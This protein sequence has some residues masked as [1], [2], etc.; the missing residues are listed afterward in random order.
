VDAGNDQFL[1]ARRLVT[2]KQSADGG[3]GGR[4]TRVNF[5]LSPIITVLRF[6]HVTQP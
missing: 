3:G 2:A 4:E 6:E 1:T 5:T